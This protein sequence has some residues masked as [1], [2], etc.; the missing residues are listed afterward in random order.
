MKKARVGNNKKYLVFLA[1]IIFF[2]AVA[3][4]RLWLEEKEAYEGE[5]PLEYGNGKCMD[6]YLAIPFYNP[7]SKDITSLKIVVP[8]GIETNFTL[9]ADFNVAEPLTP[10]KNGV[11]KLV[12]CKN[13]IDISNFDL[14]WCCES[15]CYNVKMNR[16]TNDIVVV[17]E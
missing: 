15:E 6:G 5:C 9:P 7:G 3:A 13:E 16:P 4:V 2:L 14:Q 10:G 8:S 12:T 1:I 11:L 17:D